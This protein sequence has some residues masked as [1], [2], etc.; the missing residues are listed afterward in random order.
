MSFIQE[1]ITR[2]NLG[3]SKEYTLIQFNDV[4]AVTY[5]KELDD[6]K[7]LIGQSTGKNHG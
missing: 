3:L 1:N 2:L 6:H 4:H 7:P 5:D